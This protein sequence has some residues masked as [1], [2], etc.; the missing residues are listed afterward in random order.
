[1][2]SAG[3]VVEDM[4]LC[5]VISSIGKSARLNVLLDSLAGQQDKNFVVGIC[6]QSADGSVTETARRFKDVLQ[7]FV[8]QS[9]RGL[10]K[11]RNAVV[12]SAPSDV[13][14][15][16][17]PNDTSV[18]PAATVADLRRLHTSVDILAMR[19]MDSG[20]ARYEFA[21]GAIPISR[22]NVWQIIEPAMLLSSKAFNLAGG[23][24]EELGTGCGTPWQ[25]G[26]GTDLLLKIRDLNLEVVWDP[27]IQVLG[28]AENHGLTPD[29]YRKKL[30]SYG[31]GYG[32]L[33]AK[34]SY[35]LR[36]KLR[37]C[38]SPWFKALPPDRSIALGDAAAMC[39]GRVE[40][41]L[42]RIVAK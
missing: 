19:Y 23:F 8:V 31:R 10:S 5:V 38:V 17:F 29:E 6:D 33:Y 3:K 28:V 24:D 39:L 1:M 18:L 15:F 9:P 16:M 37:I 13:T 41:I 25:S 40:G 26:E 14:H 11:G 36:A 30:R 12:R 20:H 21:P 2:P 27:S 7:I 4:R 42:G 32:Y 34:W 22:S 35:P